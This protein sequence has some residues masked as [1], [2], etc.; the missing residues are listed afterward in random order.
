VARAVKKKAVRKAAAPKKPPRRSEA[1]RSGAGGAVHGAAT[2]SYRAKVRMY[3]Q[4]LGDC[5]L[6]SLPRN[7]GGSRPFYVM[8]DCGVVL[9]TPDPGTIMKQVMDNIVEVTGG[10]IDI[11][12]ATHEHWDHLSG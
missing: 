9:G 7:D 4:G 1:V 10:E 5:F 11:L 6:I 3:R 2:A 8:I 12:I